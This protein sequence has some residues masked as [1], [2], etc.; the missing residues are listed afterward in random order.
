[1][2]QDIRLSVRQKILVHILSTLETTGGRIESYFLTQSG[3]AQSLNLPRAHIAIEIERAVTKGLVFSK[4]ARVRGKRE[5]KV[6]A[7]TQR[8]IEEAERVRDEVLRNRRIRDAIERPELYDPT[9]IFKDLGQPE[10]I[11]LCALAIAE[12]PLISKMLGNRKVPYAVD[13]GEFI[14]IAEVAKEAIRE[15][16]QDEQIKKK[17]HSLLADYYLMTGELHLM[18]KEL[19]DAGRFR[20]ATR[21]VEMHCEEFERLGPEVKLPLLLR[22]K[23]ATG[24]GGVFLARYLFEAGHYDE[25]LKEIERSE[26]SV[27]ADLMRLLLLHIIGMECHTPIPQAHSAREKSLFHRVMAEQHLKAGDISGGISEMREARRIA[28]ASE[29]LEELRMIY[30]RLFELEEMMGD[31]IEASRIRM[32][33]NSIQKL[34]GSE[35][36]ELSQ[37]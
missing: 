3:I 22:L 1:L 19:L 13:D 25:A 32:K 37:F 7:L 10:R 11:M 30:R 20:E 17:A 18:L 23:E 2:A 35:N 12:R 24:Q 29:D 14:T 33:L 15:M 8:G 5:V 21:C 28:A 26:G 4:H 6:Y 16:L 9:T 34:R 31:E 27:E 36:R